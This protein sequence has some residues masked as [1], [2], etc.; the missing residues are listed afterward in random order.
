MN[1]SFKL[2]NFCESIF[3]FLFF[4]RKE[5]EVYLLSRVNKL[6]SRNIWRNY[7]YKIV[8]NIYAHFFFCK[9]FHVR[10]SFICLI[11]NKIENEKF[12]SY[13]KIIFTLG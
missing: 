10:I 3:L 11:F 9:Y 12:V 1:V 5:K 6:N 13:V 4:R 8:N 7:S 2:I